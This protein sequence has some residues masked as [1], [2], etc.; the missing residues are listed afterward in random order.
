MQQNMCMCV[1]V[2]VFNTFN[3]SGFIG[4]FSKNNEFTVNNVIK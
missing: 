4:P 3:T 1:C 2:C